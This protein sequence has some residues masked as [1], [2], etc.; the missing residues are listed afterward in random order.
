MKKSDCMRSRF[1]RLISVWGASKKSSRLSAM[2]ILSSDCINLTQE[3]FVVFKENFCEL[4]V[5]GARD[6]AVRNF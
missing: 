4:T 2:Q 5:K 1:V 3:A 6:R